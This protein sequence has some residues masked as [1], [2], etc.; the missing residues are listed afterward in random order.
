MNNPHQPLG[1]PTFIQLVCQN[2]YGIQM[3]NTFVSHMSQKERAKLEKTFAKR[4][5][6]NMI[7]P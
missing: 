2:N 4:R 7:K 1:Q 5:H 6:T 3:G